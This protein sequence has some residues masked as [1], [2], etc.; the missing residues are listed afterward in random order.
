MDLPILMLR[1]GCLPWFVASRKESS[2][3]NHVRSCVNLN[4][5]SV[6]T[7][8]L[9]SYNTQHS[10]STISTVV[11]ILES[12]KRA[13]ERQQNPE[14]VFLLDQWY[15]IANPQL[16]RHDADKWL[17]ETSCNVVVPTTED[18]LY[19]LARGFQAPSEPWALPQGR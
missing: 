6:R 18:I 8:L 3:G 14:F 5:S 9:T 17:A 12:P 11:T 16:A 10:I 4:S 13:G 1:R 7:S 2:L 15:N 19:C